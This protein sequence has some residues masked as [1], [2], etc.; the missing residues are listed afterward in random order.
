MASRAH[1][2][3]SSRAERLSAVSC[4]VPQR[5]RS[6][7]APVMTATS[8]HLGSFLDLLRSPGGVELLR[9]AEGAVTTTSGERYRCTPSGI[10]LFAEQP[11]TEAARVQQAHYDRIASAY[12]TNLAYPHTQEFMAYFD[13]KFL[14]QL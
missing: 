3:A 11:E 8:S 2:R 12:L 10:P 9:V 4:D 1:S 6:G 7:G 14:E 13:R 5:A